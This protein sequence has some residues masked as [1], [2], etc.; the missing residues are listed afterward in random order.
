MK[1]HLLHL[2]MA[3]TLAIGTAATSTAGVF[4]PTEYQAQNDKN[5]PFRFMP[6]KERRNTITQQKI[7]NLLRAKGVVNLEPETTLTAP[8]TPE[9]QMFSVRYIYGPNEETW[10]YTMETLY[11]VLPG[12]NEYYQ[13]RS[14]NGLIFTL[15]NEK[16]EKMG[17]FKGNV[18]LI[19]G[20]IRC[21]NMQVDLSVTKNF[22]NLDD[23]Y[24]ITVGCNYNP[25]VG[26]GA[27]QVTYV[28]SL[29][30][31]EEAQ[32]PLYA[33]PGL[34]GYEVNIGTAT[35]ENFVM[36]FMD[37]STWPDDDRTAINY[38][39]YTRFTYDAN[40]P[41]KVEDLPIITVSGDEAVPMQMTANGNKLYAASG[42]YEKPLFGSDDDETT[43]NGN[44]YVITLYEQ[45]RGRFVE[46]K[47][48]KIP[49]PDV[50][51]GFVTSEVS[52]G[53]FRGT[54]DIT[55]EFGDGQLPCYVLE[56]TQS[57]ATGNEEVYYAV[58]D[59]D[60]KELKRFGENS[61]GFMQLSNLDGYEEQFAFLT[62]KDGTAVLQ[63]MNWPS[64]TLGAALPV[65]YYDF[66]SGETFN[67]SRN[68]D[69][70]PGK[71]GYYYVSSGANGITTDVNT[72]HRIAYFDGN[73]NMDHIDVLTFK[74]D[75]TKV[76]PYID[77]SVLDPY[78]FNS[79]KNFEYLAWLERK[80]SENPNAAVKVLAILDSKGNIIAEREYRLR[81][82]Y[83][84]CYVANPT[85]GSAYM[86]VMYTDYYGQ[87]SGSQGVESRLEMIKLPFNKFEGEGTVENPYLIKTFGDF[88]QIRNNLTS[89]FRL[90]ADID[91]E[92]RRMLQIPGVF[93]GSIDGAG[94]Q[95]R[96]IVVAGD[97]DNNGMFYQFGD[98]ET[99]TQAFMKDIT[100]NNISM[101]ISFQSFR[102][103]A[104]G[105]LA[106]QMVNSRLDNVHLIN[107]VATTNFNERGT[108]TNPIFGGFAARVNGCSINEC[109]VLNADFNMPNSYVGGIGGNFIGEGSAI[110]ACAFTG[111]IVGKNN[112]GGIAGYVNVDTSINDVHVNAD[113][114]GTYRV[115]GVLGFA[116][117]GPAFISRALV[118]GTVTSEDPI[119]E[120]VILNPDK[121]DN[122]DYI[123]GEAA[124]H[125]I[126]GIAGDLY[127]GSV[128]NSVVALD[129]LSWK[130]AD[131]EFYANRIV[132][133]GSVKGCHALSTL[134]VGETESCD[135]ASVEKDALTSEWFTSLGFVAGASVDEPWNHAGELP[136][137]HFEEAAALYLG[138]DPAE[139]EGAVGTTVN[140]VV[141]YE[142]F[143]LA[144]EIGAGLVQFSTANE[145][146]AEMNGRMEAG[147]GQITIEVELKSVGETTFT[148]TA[149]G[150]TATATI[151]VK[152][153]S[154]VADVMAD[155]AQPNDPV[156]NL[157]GIKVGTREGF[158]NLPSGLYIMGGQKIFKR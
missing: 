69:R 38:T 146:V 148:I 46:L 158:D 35:S 75:V 42:L 5:N 139:Y 95:V 151:T 149:K 31:K 124:Y 87:T 10:A 105:L 157:Q 142:G 55:F 32:D 82:Q 44:N 116:D 126:G 16:G 66:D 153:L 118:E 84:Q 71:G 127:S 147:E 100:F 27:K 97:N 80:S 4:S 96:N 23:Y 59:T 25:I 73:G 129:D 77:A 56:F 49:V 154:G 12:S 117:Q 145:A 156:Y 8:Y 53:T 34:P 64:L 120:R 57:S 61:S 68:L 22:Y 134:P 109:S 106:Y 113:I 81:Q 28:Y 128:S 140:V 119:V 37:Y 51:E 83:F 121:G 91:G 130:K 125:Y 21:Y 92:G 143:D 62:E 101:N 43:Q 76:L 29:N 6:T 136:V 131:Q 93:Q 132:G 88:N 122:E 40:G 26:T 72:V 65:S 144:E 111:K 155:Q 141:K 17:S 90:A 102:I 133:S 78:L 24:E 45:Q 150:K 67:L 108:F 94:H 70:C 63:M 79:D 107:A 104:D 99:T 47:Q 137:L 74:A 60:G 18:P 3:T 1:R 103:K 39:V 110:N 9:D 30:N 11:D 36:M 58:Y 13:D 86:C 20:A 41:T 33:I 15:Y 52:L 152:D 135:G 48:T 98:G 115:G 138:C 85:S 123:Y 2:A 7:N 89:H 19:D 54:D 14:Y 112:V 114:T 50:K